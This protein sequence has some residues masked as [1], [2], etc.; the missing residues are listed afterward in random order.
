MFGLTRRDWLRNFG[1][2]LG[3]LFAGRSLSQSVF[4]HQDSETSGIAFRFVHLTDIHV[5]PELRADA[6]MAA[7]LQHVSQLN[8]RPDFIIT[9]GDLIMDA[10]E[11][12]AQR[13]KMLFNLFTRVLKDN[14]DI[15]AYHCLGNHDVFGWGKKHGVTP[16]H[17]GYG[18]RMYCETFG[19]EKTYY[20]FD[21]KGWRFYI[22]DSVQP[23]ETGLYQGGL[24][25]EQWAWFEDQLRS[26]PADM[27]AVIV[28]H[29]P[30]LSVTYIPDALNENQFRIGPATMCAGAQRMAQLL[31]QHNGRLAIS[32]HIHMVDEV[33]YRGV[34]YVCDGAVSG[35]WWK[36]LNKGFPEGYGV[37]DV[38]ADGKINYQYVTYGW[39]AEQA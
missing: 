32:G 2:S 21:H 35:R 34:K 26:K 9:G 17:D 3:T 19:C 24:D 10:L 7:C 12:D 8:P 39:K 38:H 23:S 13:S 33:D 16:D 27:P 5:Q 4:A 36:G 1:L 30:F 37:F 31:A 6:G 20:S 28:S 18:K 25:P 22:L 14:T 15:P 29:I 11:Q